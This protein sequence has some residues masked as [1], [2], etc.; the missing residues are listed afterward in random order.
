ML[1]I[2]TNPRIESKSTEQNFSEITLLKKIVEAVNRTKST[3]LL[4]MVH[5]V[6]NK[7]G[8]IHS[9]T[10]CVCVCLCVCVCVCVCVCAY[11]LREEKGRKRCPTDRPSDRACPVSEN[12]PLFLI[13]S[14]RRHQFKNI[15]SK[16]ASTSVYV[17]SFRYVPPAAVLELP[18][19]QEKENE[20]HIGMLGGTPSQTT[21]AEKRNLVKETTK[22]VTKKTF[23]LDSCD[24]LMDEIEKA[25]DVVGVVVRKEEACTTQ[26]SSQNTQRK[27]KFATTSSNS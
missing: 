11:V 22:E 4:L 5:K 23:Q 20:P 8:Y 16:N 17:P 1:K 26:S 14:Q 13:M 2:N 21:C 19:Q 6:R 25:Y 3:D 9:M 12:R 27:K 18:Q 24:P 10:R 15:K 7:F